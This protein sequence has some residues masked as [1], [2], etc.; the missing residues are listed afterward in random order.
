MQDGVHAL[1]IEARRN[2]RERD[3]GAPAAV[4]GLLPLGVEEPSALAVG[5]RPIR[6]G[7]RSFGVWGT[8]R[9]GRH[10]VEVVDAERR[11][12]GIGGGI[13]DRVEPRIT[14][15]VRLYL[16]FGGHD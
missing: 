11:R 10:V 1:R 3:G 15:E 2:A 14:R 16:L 13:F 5:P 9:L 7:P 6:R 12:I 8:I 4:I